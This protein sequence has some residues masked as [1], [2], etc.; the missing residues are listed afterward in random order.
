MARSG[1]FIG[2]PRLK[3]RKSRQKAESDVKQQAPFPPDRGSGERC[4]IPSGFGAESRPPK[5]FP[6]F[7]ALR[8]T[9]PD[10]IIIVDYHAAVGGRLP[11]LPLCM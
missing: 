11:W 6:L 1:F 7:S 2:R 5:G 3:G 4:E 9:S 8:M 10:S